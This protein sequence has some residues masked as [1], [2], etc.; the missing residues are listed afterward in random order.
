MSTSQGNEQNI[1]RLREIEGVECNY[2]YLYTNDIPA[3]RKHSHDRLDAVRKVCKNVYF[4]RYATT[5]KT[6]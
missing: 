6:F 4:D 5:L 3:Q 2:F 1:G